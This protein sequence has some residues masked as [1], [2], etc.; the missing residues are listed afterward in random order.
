[1]EA[2]PL[3][4]PRPLLNWGP[5]ILFNVIAPTLTYF[6]LTGHGVGEV[7]ALLA[8][9]AWPVVE[10]GVFFALHRRVDEFSIF[11]LILLGLSLVAALGFNSPRL[12]LVKDSAITGLFGL[13]VLASFALRRPLMFYFGR[14]FATNGT[15]ESIAWWNGLWQYPGFRRTQYVI[16]AVWGVTFLA[17]ALARIALSYVLSTGTM[18]L[19]TAVLPFVVIGTLVTWTIGYGKRAR[20]RAP[21]TVAA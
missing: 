7:P 5:T 21:Q 1:M 12:I 17:E 20:A 15:P 4:K 2:A 8:S 6:L 11:V 3:A 13:A 18:V 10:L 16:N 14:K 9:G 19:V